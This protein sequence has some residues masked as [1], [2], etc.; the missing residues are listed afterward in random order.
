MISDIRFPVSAFKRKMFLPHPR[1]KV[2][3]VGGLRDW[4]VACSASD[5]QGSNFES[6]VWRTV[7]SQSSHHPQEVLLAQF[8]LYVHKGGLNP[9][10]FI[11]NIRFAWFI[12][13]QTQDC[14]H[15]VICWKL[16]SRATYSGFLNKINEASF[17][18]VWQV[19]L[20]T[21]TKL[22][23]VI[24]IILKYNYD[25]LKNEVYSRYLRHAV[26]LVL[27]LCYW[28]RFNPLNPEFT[29]VIFIYYKPRSQ[30]MKMAWSEWQRKKINFIIKKATW[31]CTFQNPGFK[32]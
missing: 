7:S 1:V 9:I 2:S 13:N 25:W 5:R 26:K 20:L 29:I 22:M 23:R 19:N 17:F 28:G 6:C 3:I 4:E 32:K 31:K 18:A 30:W 11:Y 15:G 21:F 24:L 16:P 27:P 12:S 10:H 14:A 8:S